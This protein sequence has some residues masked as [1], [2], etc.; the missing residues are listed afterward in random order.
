MEES[1]VQTPRSQI[2]SALE[3]INKNRRKINNQNKLDYM[4]VGGYLINGGKLRWHAESKSSARRT[5]QYY[6]VGIGLEGPSPRQLGKMRKEKFDEVF[7]GRK[8][9]F[10]EVLLDSPADDEGQPRDRVTMHAM[11]RT[12]HSS[13]VGAVEISYA[14]VRAMIDI[15]TEGRTHGENPTDEDKMTASQ[16]DR[17]RD[18]AYSARRPSTAERRPLTA[19][20]RHSI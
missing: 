5:Y 17:V 10:G 19:D 3:R 16:K 7:M 1:L 8:L 13:R 11:A 14:E 6:S 4:L 2:D 20:R 12:M 9:T 18:T 15:P